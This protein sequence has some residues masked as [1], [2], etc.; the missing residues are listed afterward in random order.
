M[1]YE[2]KN[3]KQTNMEIDT[4]FLIQQSTKQVNFRLKSLFQTT[5]YKQ[6]AKKTNIMAYKQVYSLLSYQKN[7]KQ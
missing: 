1:S 7:L 5:I 3:P 6:Y 2:S 4:N